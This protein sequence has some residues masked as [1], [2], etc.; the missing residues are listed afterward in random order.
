MTAPHSTDPEVAAPAA[1]RPAVVAAP[2]VPPSMPSVA[3]RAFA[4]VHRNVVPSA[5]LV[6][7]LAA[8]CS[9]LMRND[10]DRSWLMA[11]CAVALGSVISTGVAVVVFRHSRSSGIPSR[12]AVWTLRWALLVLGTWFGISTWVGRT[13]TTEV[14][15]TFML[16][17]AVAGAIGAVLTSGR[18]DLFAWLMI[19]TVAV[20][21]AALMTSSNDLLRNFAILSLFYVIVLVVIHHVV[22]ASLLESIRLQRHTDE[23]LA[24]TKLHREQLAMV[25]AELAASNQQLGLQATHDS[26]TNLLNR[27]GV[28]DH[29][30]RQ[31]RST[32]RTS[33]LYVDLDYFKSINDA[34]GHRGGDQFLQ[35]IAERLGAVVPD[36]GEAGRI[37]GD[38]FIVVLPEH[39]AQAAL[40][41]ASRMSA[42]LSQ[43][44]HVEGRALMS[45]VSV[46]LAC[47]P[48]HASATSTLL[49]YANAALHRAKAAGRNRIEL[50]DS[51]MQ[52][53]LE[54]RRSVEHELRTALDHG[55]IT[56]FMQP[57]LDATDGVVVGA[58]LLARWIRRN[59]EVVSA[60][61]FLGDAHSSGLLERVT[62][63]VMA[64]AR[65]HIR[66]MSLL[67][68][69]DGFR[70]R[71]NVAPDGSTGS[72]RTHSISTLTNGV[73][74]GLL[75]I[76]VTERVV[77]EDTTGAVAGLAAFR[78]SGG[79]VC[80][81][82]FA[83]GM[84]SL[85]TLRRLPLDEVRIDRL[86][87]DTIT[88]HPHD[89]VIVRSIIGLVR[90]LGM[91]VT[92]DGV[93]NGAQADVLIALGCVRHQ[94]R[95]YAPPMQPS[96]FED[97][98]LS[99]L[100]ISQQARG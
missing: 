75:T 38:E 3:D 31:L 50:F 60:S 80:L 81:D 85:A 53:D 28:L 96:E 25:N 94:G 49:R 58:E 90:E 17:P 65:P 87:I 26:L 43:R 46:G 70:F 39:D 67:G 18:R 6:L 40:A 66:R 33:V 47:S 57:E 19:P 44:V 7:P 61:E 35:V 93:E 78:A 86:A 21:T 54:R 42:V 74:A 14:T 52:Q 59:G 55:D 24:D 4:I 34:V 62:E 22:A 84:S 76:D 89:R 92:A 91:T 29:L 30:D 63:A 15:A 83:R 36:G 16:F 8:L 68:L 64:S 71:V 72:W 73:P 45:S 100:A 48:T 41:V 5:A 79:R 23:L 13:G 12:P 99:R 1:T 27:R 32:P 69:P 88:S 37:G 56:A 2:E 10:V 11:W 95:L 98:L 9:G 20:S 82:D 97:F 77:A 51:V